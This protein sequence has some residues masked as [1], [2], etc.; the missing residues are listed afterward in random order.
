MRKH[1]QG[2]IWGRGSRHGAT[3]GSRFVGFSGLHPSQ[4][5][6]R[7][8]NS[9]SR[10]R[11]NPIP[12]A[13]ARRYIRTFGRCESAEMRDIQCS[14][15]GLGEILLHPVVLIGPLPRQWPSA[16]VEERAGAKGLSW[17]SWRKELAAFPKPVSPPASRTGGCG[18]A[19]VA[20]TFFST[21]RKGW[22]SLAYVLLKVL[23]M[24]P[25][26][27]PAGCPP[28]RLQRVHAPNFVASVN[29]LCWVE[30]IP[31]SPVKPSDRNPTEHQQNHESQKSHQHYW[32]HIWAPNSWMKVAVWA[33]LKN[34]FF[35]KCF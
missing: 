31:H 16:A 17:G 26:R 1:G 8:W 6:K 30:L 32:G 24:W 2:V 27:W 33:N 25:H 29:P 7:C 10:G 13:M 23:W 18:Y 21:P 11:A 28:L 9:H 3:L 4:L 14:A 12:A 5:Q 34:L 35:Q 22:A 15:G 19:W 20:S